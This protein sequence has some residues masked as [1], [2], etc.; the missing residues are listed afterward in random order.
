MWA[1]PRF[2]ADRLSAYARTA[3]TRLGVPAGDAAAVAE[4]LV[5]AELEGQ[6]SLGLQ[7]LPALIGRLRE[8]LI[9]PDPAFAVS[10]EREAVALLDAGNALGPVAGLRAVE[11]AVE[12]ARRAGIGLVA[13][14]RSNHLGT[15]SFYLRRFAEQ[16]VIG[17]VF[18]N[19]PPA[20]APPGSSTPYL[21]T[22]PIG[23]GVPT[24][25]QPV[26]LDMAI[27]QLAGGNVLKA[28]RLAEPVPEGWAV[29]P[30]GQG[31]AVGAVA[32]P[33][34]VASAGSD[35][36]FALALLVEVLAGVLSGAAIGPEVGRVDP[37]AD[38]ESDV[39]HCFI[40]VDPV[41]T[42]PDFIRRMD[43]VVTDLRRLSGQAPGDRRHASRERRL[44]TGIELGEELVVDLIDATGHGI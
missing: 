8:G 33:G 18:S 24:S 19:T 44:A 41:A 14:R 10:G 4:S 40:A 3:V 2:T 5:E 43:Q 21:G 25:G 16:G 15:I 17:L 26:L 42:I 7:R 38:R 6:P 39:G 29:G 35:K 30:E 1:M 36:A 23:A 22:N 27:S 28:A 9:D 12:R 20:L 11:L 31:G 32:A 37:P 34:T 13:V